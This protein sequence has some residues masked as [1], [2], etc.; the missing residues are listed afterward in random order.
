MV[1]CSFAAITFGTPVHVATQP[2]RCG[3][4]TS[5]ASFSVHIPGMSSGDM[6]VIQMESTR[7]KSNAAQSGRVRLFGVEGTRAFWTVLL[8]VVVSVGLGVGLGLGIVLSPSAS[9]SD[10]ATAPPPPLLSPAPPPPLLPSVSAVSFSIRMAGDL[11][12]FTTDVIGELEASPHGPPCAGY[13][14]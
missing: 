13:C 12:S 5:T 2:P 1:C 9:S 4:A 6:P 14:S 3:H 7:T 11:S 10:T 8:L